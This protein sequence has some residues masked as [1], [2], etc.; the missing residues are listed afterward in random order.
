[1]GSNWLDKRGQEYS[2]ITAAKDVQT[3]EIVIVYRGEFGEREI[4]CCPRDAFKR[5]FK[6]K[7]QTVNIPIKTVE[8]DDT[9]EKNLVME[10][11]DTA[12]FSKKARILK[13][14]YIVGELTDNI[15]DNFAATLD[16]VIESGDLASRYDNLRICVETRAKYETGRYSR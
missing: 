9:G 2:V 8:A 13:Q 12:D 15:I 14:L 10:F 6:P 7:T 1:M 16:V 4:F 5:S 11:F 3:G